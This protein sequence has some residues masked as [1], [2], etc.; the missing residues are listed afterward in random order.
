MNDYI[1]FLDKTS[2][3]HKCPACECKSFVRYVHRDTNEYE[4][5]DEYGRCDKDK[6]GYFNKVTS[7]VI[8]DYKQQNNIKP[9]IQPIIKKKEG[10]FD[11]I[12]DFI[13]LNVFTDSLK[14]YEKNRLVK[15]LY[16]S[17]ETNKVDEAIKKYHVGTSKKYNGGTVFWQVCKAGFVRG[18]SIMAY[19]YKTGKRIKEDW[20]VTYVHSI[21]NLKPF[22][23]GRVLFGEHLLDDST[24][25]IGIVESEKTAL[26]MSIS[27]PNTTWLA[28]SGK[29]NFKYQL[30][31]SLKPLSQNAKIIAYPDKG[32]YDKWNIVA[33]EIRGDIQITVSDILEKDEYEDGCDIADVI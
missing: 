13:D 30:L 27:A 16:N 22:C 28:T 33:N 18:G 29:V 12:P 25:K 8:K 31:S 10:Y 21:L 4:L 17:F 26:I 20:A 3:K 6:C 9:G 19:D 23:Y 14:D 24:K 2:K 5:P 11:K 7:E 32:G 1:F 15:Y